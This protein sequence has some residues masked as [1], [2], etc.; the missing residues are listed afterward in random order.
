MM[1][2]KLCLAKCLLRLI[3]ADRPHPI[4]DTRQMN[5]RRR[6]E[7]ISCSIR[8]FGGKHWFA[9]PIH[10]DGTMIIKQSPW[11]RHWCGATNT[12]LYWFIRNEKLKNP[13]DLRI[14]LALNDFRF[15]KTFE[16]KSNEANSP[17]NFID[18]FMFFF[19]P[20]NEA[21]NN[22][23]LIITFVYSIREKRREH[24]FIWWE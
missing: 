16:Q 4:H 20:E 15:G 17:R 5:Q 23:I 12:P 9:S 21:V 24:F 2:I 8:V 19:L 11:L 13:L 10:G 18:N 3:D 6:W 14:E 7:R 22:W 1:V